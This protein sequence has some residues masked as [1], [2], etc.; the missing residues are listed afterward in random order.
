MAFLYEVLVHSRNL[1]HDVFCA[2]WNTLASET[3]LQ[4]GH[5]GLVQLIELVVGTLITSLKSLLDDDMACRTGTHTAAHMLQF[6]AVSHSDVEEA[7]GESG[8]TIRNFC[9]I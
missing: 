2:V 8:L 5:W 1:H 4:G 9:W 6:N 3:G 7:A